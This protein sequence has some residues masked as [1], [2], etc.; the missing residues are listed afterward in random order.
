MPHILTLQYVTRPAML[1][2]WKEAH[3]S[4]AFLFLWQQASFVCLLTVPMGAVDTTVIIGAFRSEACT[5][6]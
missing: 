5:Q 4:C 6:K 1:F 3:L 2:P